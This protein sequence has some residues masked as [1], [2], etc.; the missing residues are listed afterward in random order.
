MQQETPVGMTGISFVCFVWVQSLLPRNDR[1]AANPHPDRSGG[2]WD[3][4]AEITDR[5]GTGSAL[6]IGGD[7]PQNPRSLRQGREEGY[8]GV[9]RSTWNDGRLPSRTDPESSSGWQWL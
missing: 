3:D 7:V 9:V 6:L 1:R 8:S 4:Y 2:T 5:G